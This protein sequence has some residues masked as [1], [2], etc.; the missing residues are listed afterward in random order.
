MSLDALASIF[1]MQRSG[2]LLLVRNR[3]PRRNVNRVVF[4]Y[5]EATCLVNAAA[6]LASLAIRT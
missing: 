4:S 6:H 5:P 3:S 1:L 2:E